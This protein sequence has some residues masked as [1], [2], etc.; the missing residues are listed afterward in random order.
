[1]FPWFL[2]ILETNI[3]RLQQIWN[4]SL[5]IL[6]GLPRESQTAFFRYGFKVL[7]LERGTNLSFLKAR[8]F[9]NLKE[10]SK[11]NAVFIK[12]IYIR[13]S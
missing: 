10:L 2:D 5:I 3:R 7:I 1:V 12:G 9:N 4:L 8:D 11:V 6:E 13:S